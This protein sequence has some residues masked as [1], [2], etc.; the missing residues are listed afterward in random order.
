M[1]N[2]HN[3]F[4]CLEEIEPCEEDGAR[5]PIKCSVSKTQL[6]DVLEGDARK[7]MITN[8]SMT[9]DLIFVNRYM[10]DLGLFVPLDML[11][12]IVYHCK[13]SEWLHDLK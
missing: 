5:M 3:S 4:C 13:S 7:V 1:T 8:D 10:R 11:R 6:M 2:H 9:Y 12:L